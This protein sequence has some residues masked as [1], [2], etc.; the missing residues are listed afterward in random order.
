[1][2]TAKEEML[3]ATKQRAIDFMSVDGSLKYDEALRIAA[4]DVREEA[5]DEFAMFMAY[6]KTP[7]TTAGCPSPYYV[8]DLEKAIWEPESL[9]PESWDEDEDA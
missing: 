3:E 6:M 9:Y 4:Q 7:I 1:V 2:R 5:I 8:D